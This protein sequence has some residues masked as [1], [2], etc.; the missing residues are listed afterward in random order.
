MLLKLTPE[1]FPAGISL[2]AEARYGF[3]L[4]WTTMKNRLW[5]SEKT[6]RDIR[7]SCRE[8]LDA[9]STALQEVNEGRIEVSYA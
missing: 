4:S 2:V 5:L 9:V 6:R 3:G 7:W 8:V 1:T